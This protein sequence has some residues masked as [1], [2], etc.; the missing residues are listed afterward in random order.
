MVTDRGLF[1]RFVPTGATAVA[2]PRFCTAPA[3]YLHADAATA[4]LTQAKT[5]LSTIVGLEG[6]GRFECC[7]EAAQIF[8]RNSLKDRRACTDG[9][10]A[11]CA[12]LTI[13]G[14][15]D[16]LRRSPC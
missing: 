15:I 14:G 1:V 9:R 12:V 2:E 7:W 4:S 8:W 6:H 5:K 16:A 13:V 11:S 3:N 10:M